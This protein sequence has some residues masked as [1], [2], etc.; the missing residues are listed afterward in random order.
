MTA[1]T[2]S[3][4]PQIPDDDLDTTGLECLLVA[5]SRMATSTAGELARTIYE[6]KSALG[7]QTALPAGS[8]QPRPRRTPS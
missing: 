2:L 5:Q 3:A 4:S 7:L 1:G 6:N 8:S